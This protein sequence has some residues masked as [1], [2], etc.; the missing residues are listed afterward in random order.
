LAKKAEVDRA[1]FFAILARGWGFVVGPISALLIATRFT[2][3]IQGYYYSF[4]SLLALQTF[5]ELSLSVVIVQFAS[6]EWSNLELNKKGFI[7]GKT[8]SFSRLVSLAHIATKWYIT[9]SIL[10]VLLLGIGGYI[11]F[12]HSPNVT[13]DWKMPWLILCVI[14][15]LH[16]CVLPFLSL[17]EGCNQVSKTYYFRLIFAIGASL[18]AWIAIL[19]GAGLWTA[20]ISSLVSLI[21]IGTLILKNYCP[22]FKSLFFSHPVG[23]RMKWSSDIFPLQW[24]VALSR[25]GGYFQGSL[26]TPILFHYHGP[27]IA[28]Q[29]GMAWGLV[30]AL[31]NFISAWLAPKIPL[32]GIFVARRDYSSLNRLFWRLMTITLGL[33]CLTAMMIWGLVYILY[34]Y[35]FSIATRVLPPLPLALF[36]LATVIAAI[37]FP[38]SLYMR[39][40]K[41]EPLLF[42]SV[43][44]G[45]L[46]C[47]ST[48]ILGKYFSAMGV[49]AGYLGVNIVIVPMMVLVWYRFRAAWSPNHK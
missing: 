40:H 43:L 36:L 33:A 29:M 32:F 6:H 45:A 3:E 46:S 18:S 25:I 9:A 42:L 30:A 1:V 5:A 49:G 48:V 24:R 34:E 13:V 17:L 26:F 39:A 37:A 14:T 44:A 20:P 2:P 4:A 16:L 7:V 12:S 47:L 28:G 35:G 31:E 8:D 19:S 10:L 22:F 38:M 41:Q 11:F 21:C 27:V 23:P 15:G